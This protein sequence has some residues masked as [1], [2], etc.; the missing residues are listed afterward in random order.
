MPLTRKD[1]TRIRQIVRKELG[2]EELRP[3]QT[4]ALTALLE[5]SDTLAVLP[6]GAG[7]SAI[8]QIAALML[9]GPT[10][11]VSPLIALQRDQVEAIDD[12]GLAPAA[13]V[14]STQGVSE[15]R[16]VLDQIA[17]EDV[18]FVLLSPEQLQNEETFARVLASKPSLFVV[19]E[20]HCISQW[21]HDFRP[22]YLRLG[23]VVEALGHPR[24]LA[25]TATANDEVKREIVERLGMRDAKVVVTGFDRP[26]IW[27]GAELCADDASKTTALVRR[28]LES[29]RPGIVYAATRKRT[30]ELV[31]ALS[32]QGIRAGAYHAG[33]KKDEREKCQT[34]FMSDELEV[35]VATTAFGM[36]I[37]KPNVRF[38]FHYDLSDSLDAYYQEIGR[39]GRDGEPATAILYNAAKDAGLRRFFASTGK[40]DRTTIEDVAE[41]VTSES[42][43]IDPKALRQKTGLSQ[44]KVTKALSR[45]EDAGLVATS[46]SGELTVTEPERAHEAIEQALAGEEQRRQADRERVDKMRAYAELGTCRRVAL[47]AHF[48]EEL[49]P[50]CNACDVCEHLRTAELRLAASRTEPTTAAP[51]ERT[52][53]ASPAAELF[54]IDARV[55]HP[56]LGLGTVLGY[57]G[58]HE[59][60]IVVR[61]DEGGERR[62]A[63]DH[64]RREHLLEIAPL[65]G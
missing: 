42:G 7:K 29:P 5:G 21:G 53:E 55:E 31:A 61:F 65:R 9:P 33:L 59:E 24:V 40:V 17:N 62:L 51:A 47:L 56:T 3:P 4:E 12:M 8:Y 22:D 25:L 2:H 28:V 20:A 57:E 48:G 18:E 38:V 54:P 43:A 58:E 1:W 36:G 26:N 52:I 19:D 27:L 35:V 44:Q 46:A 6:T 41:Q 64:V 23:A 50:P 13:V 30:E 16:E 15:R 11:V 34:A 60:R 10:V 39:A 49:R 32:Q 14:N 63:L 45:L 37:D